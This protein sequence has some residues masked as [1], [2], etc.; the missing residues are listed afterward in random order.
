MRWCR[1]P[2]VPDG[3]ATTQGCRPGCRPN[4]RL[5]VFSL[6]CVLEVELWKEQLHVSLARHAVGDSGLIWKEALCCLVLVWLALLWPAPFPNIISQQHTTSLWN[7]GVST[8]SWQTHWF[9]LLFWRNTWCFT[10]PN[11]VLP[12]SSKPDYKN[13]GDFNKKCWFH[14]GRGQILRQGRFEVPTRHRSHFASRFVADTWCRRPQ[15]RRWA[16][17][18]WRHTHKLCSRFGSCGKRLR[19]GILLG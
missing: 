18:L 7:S 16:R 3:L 6:P 5:L 8:S 10:G 1:L 14:R 13:G 11:Y 4:Y 2:V 12:S 9:H 19:I 15:R 17:T